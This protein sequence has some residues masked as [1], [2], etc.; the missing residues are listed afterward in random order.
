LPFEV[1]ECGKKN[2]T[3]FIALKIVKLFFRSYFFF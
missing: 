2:T 3:P 1:L